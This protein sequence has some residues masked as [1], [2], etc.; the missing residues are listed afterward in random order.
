MTVKIFIQ[1]DDGPIHVGTFQSRQKAEEYWN[2]SREMYRDK[3][4]YMPEPIYVETG[5]GKRSKCRMH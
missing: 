4:G 2:R 5:R 1:R 3:H